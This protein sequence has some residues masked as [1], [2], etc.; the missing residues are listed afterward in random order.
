MVQQE[1]TDRNKV[2]A[3]VATTAATAPAW[4]FL[5]FRPAD[6]G[7]PAELPGELYFSRA[8]VGDKTVINMLLDLMKKKLLE[9]Y[10]APMDPT[11]L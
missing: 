9:S 6:P 7:N 8:F 3:N 10:D 5:A 2:I 4:V 1:T 11:L